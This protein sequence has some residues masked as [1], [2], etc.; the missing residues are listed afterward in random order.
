[1]NLSLQHPP[2]IDSVQIQPLTAHP[3]PPSGRFY[4]KRQPL[5]KRK[6]WENIAHTR[7]VAGL[8]DNSSGKSGRLNNLSFIV[9]L[10]FHSI[11]GIVT[12]YF[13]QS[14]RSHVS[15]RYFAD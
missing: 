7:F 5:A 2:A 11:L 14:C 13:A 4:T 12:G 6:A 8:F 10:M 9:D 3:G 1:L 15:I